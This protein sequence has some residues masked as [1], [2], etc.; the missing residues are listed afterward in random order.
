MARFVSRFLLLTLS[1]V[2]TTVVAQDT[3]TSDWTLSRNERLKAV[4]AGTTFSNGIGLG[5][6]CVDRGLEVIM[7]GLPPIEAEQRTL[8]IGFGDDPIVDQ[9]WNVAADNTV[10]VSELP[11]PLARRLR[12]GGQI[13]VR[14]PGAGENGRNVRYVMDLPPSATAIDQTLADCG[15]P[16]V[17]PRD[18]ELEAIGESGL[19]ADLVWKTQPRPT[20]PFH[21]RYAKGFAVVSCI[22][23]SDGGLRDCVVETEH[24][25]DGHFGDATLAAARRGRLTNALNPDAEITPARILFRTN[26]YMEGYQPRGLAVRT[27]SRLPTREGPVLP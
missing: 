21:S 13:Q 23:A 12:E 11:A 14:V 19:P 5:V 16:L 26:Y 4:V 20:Y 17:D 10:A 2:A 1:A 22:A 3:D 6:R 7:V 25:R 18:A 27:G 9:S 8:G 24:P 15:R